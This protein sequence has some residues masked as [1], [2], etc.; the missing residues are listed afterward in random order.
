[1]LHK[2]CNHEITFHFWIYFQTPDF[3]SPSILLSFFSTLL[4]FL[5]AVPSC[6]HGPLRGPMI[7]LTSSLV[8]SPFLLFSFPTFLLSF[9]FLPNTAIALFFLVT[10]IK[11]PAPPPPRLRRLGTRRRLL[12]LGFAEMNRDPHTG[13][14][15]N[16]WISNPLEKCRR[17][18]S[19]PFYDTGI[20]FC[21]KFGEE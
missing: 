16:L 15:L 12:R 11:V 7:P 6:Y 19:E 14:F 3:F 20:G 2:Y 13:L 17:L 8:F 9:S 21:V 5:F 1:M 4:S 18:Q 10:R